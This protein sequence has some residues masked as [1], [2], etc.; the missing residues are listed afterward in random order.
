[1]TVCDLFKYSPADVAVEVL[2]SV[3]PT[4]RK[5]LD[6]SYAMVVSR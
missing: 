1:M 3:A 5:C 6:T 4:D 2:G